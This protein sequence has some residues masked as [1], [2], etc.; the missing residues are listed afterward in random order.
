MKPF[1]MALAVFLIGYI[2][3]RKYPALGAMIGLGA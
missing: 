3:G 2:V 1:F